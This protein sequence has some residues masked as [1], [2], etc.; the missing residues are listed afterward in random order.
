MAAGD[1]TLTR[2]VVFRDDFLDVASWTADSGVTGTTDGDILSLS[3]TTA[4]NGF[5]RSVPG[6]PSTTTYPLLLVRVKGS[7]AIDLKV[8]YGDASTSTFTI[9]LTANLTVPTPLSLTTGK[10]V[11]TIK[12][13]N[14]S[15]AGTNN[16]DF[17]FQFKETLTLPAVSEP[18]QFPLSRYIVELAIPT[19]EGGILQDLG[20]S[21]AQVEVAGKLI[22][23]TSPNNYSGDQ[24]W[25]VLVGTWLEANWQWFSSD[26]IA[27][28]YQIQEL[29]PVQ[30][31]GQVGYY[32]FKMRLRK[33]DILSATAQTFGSNTGSGAIQ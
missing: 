2:G 14:Q 20:S 33:V 12:L 26:R 10:T 11:S 25:D 32:G 22:S 4:T 7:G 6:T 19:R 13:Q 1:V 3:G 18:M 30:N 15:V 28:K 23:T 21:S 16:I 27:Y 29:T 8:T 5:S 24:W 9:S 31:P 17:M